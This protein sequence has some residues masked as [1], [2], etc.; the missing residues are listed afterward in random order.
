MRYQ[1]VVLRMVDGSE[2][3]WEQNLNAYGE[4]G[5]KLV[6]VEFQRAY[7]MREVDA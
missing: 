6:G 7:L 2:D 1:Y 4:A 5:Y 3:E